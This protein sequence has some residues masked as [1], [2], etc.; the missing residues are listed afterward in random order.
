MTTSK[1]TNRLI[2]EKSPYLLQHAYN[3]VEWLPWCEQAFMKAKE[4][5]KPIFL[6]IGYSTCHW[7]HVMAHE[8]FEDSEVATVLNRDYVCIKVDREERPDIDA[9]YMT[10]CQMFTG[11]GG[12]PLTIIM[13]PD[14]KP[15]WAGTYLPKKEIYG[16]IGLMELL[17]AVS[18][19]WESDRNALLSKGEQATSLLNKQQKVQDKTAEPSKT[20]L[21][22]A[23]RQFKSNYDTKWGG[24]GAAPKFPTPHNLLFLLQYSLLEKD[25]SALQM[26]RHTLTQMFRGGIYDHLGGGFSRYSTDE[27]WI[28]PHFEKML[29]D[30]AL[31]V[32]A[33]LDAYHFTNDT[34]FSMVAKHTLDYAT[35]ELLDENG[36][37]YCGQDAD[38]EGVEGK[39]Y[40]FTKKEVY[41][42]LGEEDG[43]VFCD[44][45]GIT[46]HG[47]FE[48]KNILNLL[49][50]P[51][52]AEADL[53]IKEISHKLYTYRFNRTRLHKDDK[54]LTSWNAL[55][56]AALAKAGWLLDSPSYIQTAK[57]VHSFIKTSLTDENGELKL[58]WREGEAANDGQLDDYAFY[59]YSLLE[60]YKA[61]YE[62]EYLQQAI[63]TSER[64]LDN[65]G[66][67]VHGGFFLYSKNSE[68]LIN[69][70][71]ETYDGAIPSGNSV[72]AIVLEQLSKLTG[73]IKWQQLSHHQL[74]FLMSSI[75]DYPAGHS[76][77]LLSVSQAV[78]S[79]SEL[80][81]VAAEENIPQE[82]TIFLRSAPF[83]NLTVL[84]KTLKNKEDLEK[85]APFT[86]SYPIPANGTVYYLCHNGACSS[87][88]D[89]LSSL[90]NHL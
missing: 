13:T 62:V 28:V 33:Y 55:M 58:R 57:N 4:E 69:R 14:Q 5:D 23:A 74:S 44:W 38:S 7:C 84:V 24:F 30:N 50:N 40:V 6:S 52:Y 17:E 3:P 11:S 68:Q 89:N 80:V 27:K 61:T 47:N 21:I 10:V 41:N 46:E 18:D 56:I 78:Y 42:V 83:A 72:A 65:F 59:A 20:I 71:K 64:M 51:R 66:D 8:S 75:E 86:A 54:V 49:D 32:L 81:C 35:R 1:I 45:F 19:M 25:D 70:P 26:V 67:A 16:R 36:G 77:A 48:G 22:K 29:Y 82:L 2:H 34:F 79:S 12:W 9:V 53:R 63:S 39:Y 60:L 43:A 90:F 85:A 76:M 88:T 31:L 87:P 37:F 73:E 15:F